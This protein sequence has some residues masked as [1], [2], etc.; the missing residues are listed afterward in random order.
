MRNADS[1]SFI[2]VGMALTNIVNWFFTSY[3]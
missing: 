1:N 2:M 3:L